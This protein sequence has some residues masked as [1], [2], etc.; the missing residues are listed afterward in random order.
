MPIH[1][2]VCNKPVSYWWSSVLSISWMSVLAIIGVLND[3][4]NIV[5]YL[6]V[7]PSPYVHLV[8][9]RRRSCDGYSP[10]FPVFRCSSASASVYYTE[11]K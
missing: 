2:L 6:N 1:K 8:S 5:R 9:T 4:V 7:G 11:W 10:A 3:E